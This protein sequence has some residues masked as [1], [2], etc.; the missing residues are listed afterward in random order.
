MLPQ[1]ETS[2][3]TWFVNRT[4]AVDK[5]IICVPIDRLYARWNGFKVVARVSCC[6]DSDVAENQRHTARVTTR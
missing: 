3:S 1:L 6:S 4:Q 5:Q 2:D